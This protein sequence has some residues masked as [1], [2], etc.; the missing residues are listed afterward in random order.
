MVAAFLFH[1]DAAGGETMHDLPLE[2]D[3]ST[4]Y[5]PDEVFDDAIILSSKLDQQHS[6]ICLGQFL[7]T[8]HFLDH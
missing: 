1:H 5:L 6:A 2:G 4:W 7:H 8:S 3:S